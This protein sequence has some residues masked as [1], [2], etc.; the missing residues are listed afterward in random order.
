MIRKLG[1]WLFL[2]ALI[3]LWAFSDRVFPPDVITAAVA[4]VKDGD[5]LVVNSTTFRLY[6]IDAPEYRQSCKDAKGTDWPCGKAARSQLEA[7]VHPGSITCE[8][9]AEDR[10]GRKVAKCAS[11]TVPDLAEA[12]VQ[13]GL[14]IS[15]A[16]RGTATYFDAEDSAKTAKRGIWQGSFDNPAD[17]RVLHPRGAVDPKREDNP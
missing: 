8:P 2:I 4:K 16:E 3:G 12:M 1:I 15:P 6:G 5:T 17:Y 13:S 10:Y 14:A 9:K 7:Y 11:A